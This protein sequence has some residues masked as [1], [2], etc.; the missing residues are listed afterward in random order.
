[1]SLTIENLKKGPLKDGKI[2]KDDMVTVKGTGKSEHLPKGK[3]VLV[4]SV[5]ANTLVETGKAVRV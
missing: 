3:E 1:M 2:K 5:H 4:H